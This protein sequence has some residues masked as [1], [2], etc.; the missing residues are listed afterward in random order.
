MFLKPK[1]VVEIRCYH[2]EGKFR[3]VTPLE[4][5]FRITDESGSYHV[6]P[7]EVLLYHPN[8]GDGV[9]I[10]KRS[11]WYEYDPLRGA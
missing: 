11:D 7:D 5:V 8:W 3:K 1:R 2:V 4:H 10:G 9:H 6:G